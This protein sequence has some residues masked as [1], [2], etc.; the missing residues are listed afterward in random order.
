MIVRSI[1]TIALDMDL[2]IKIY[3]SFY[4]V[5]DKR[6]E[7]S[8]LR[9]QLSITTCQKYW[10]VLSTQQQDNAML[11]YNSTQTIIRMH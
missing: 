7:H 9:R 10:T 8:F 4:I 11:E 2:I 5:Y 3:T 1:S 6:I